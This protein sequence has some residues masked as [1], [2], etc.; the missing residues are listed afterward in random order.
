M[1]QIDIMTIRHIVTL[2]F[3]VATT[4]SFAGI[5]QKKDTVKL[6]CIVCFLLLLQGVFFVSFGLDAVVTSYPIHTHMVLVGALVLC[7][8]CTVKD[9]TICTLLAYMCCQIPAWISRWTMYTMYHSSIREF[10]IY[11]FAALITFWMIVK[12]AA[13]PIHELLQGSKAETMV[14]G[15]VPVTY[16]LFDYLTT[17]WTKVLYTGNYHVAQFMPSVICVAYLV[18]AVVFSHEQKRRT[19]AMEERTIL[20][21]ELYIV[22]TETE[23]LRELSK[24]ARIHRHDMRHHLA[25]ILH[26]IEENHIEEAREYIRE[27]IERIDEFTPHRFCE[28]EMLN[29]ILSHFASQ[30]EEMKAQ[31]RFGVELPA[32]MPLT[33][34]ELCALVSNALENAFHAVRELPEEK[35]FVDARLCELNGKLIF[36]VDN[37]CDDRIQI[38]GNR[39]KTDKAGHGYGTRSIMTI[40]NEHN[41]MAVF[42][43]EN[44]M[45]S[46]MVTIPL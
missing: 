26:L 6:V 36:S 31:Y 43:S 17:V 5:L 32:Q 42:Q 18:F 20:Q 29:L 46:L 23:S 28:M 8:Q 22:E 40:A 19:E 30:A 3:G 44:G 11:F 39:P 41:G 4:A 9:A 1:V 35:R 27:N 7:F 38:T 16:Y 2:L 45:F 14:M 10:L 25:L 12:Y 37:S 13:A 15:I 21:N 33:K 24:L 34:P